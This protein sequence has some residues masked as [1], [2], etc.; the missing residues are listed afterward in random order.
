[1]LTRSRRAAQGHSWAPL[2]RFG[3]RKQLHGVI[4]LCESASVRRLRVRSG[5]GKP[6]VWG[7]CSFPP[8][9]P[10]SF[11]ANEAPRRLCFHPNHPSTR[12]S[13][14]ADLTLGDWKAGAQR[15]PRTSLYEAGPSG[16]GRRM[17]A[18]ACVPRAV[19]S[20]PHLSPTPV[21]QPHPALAL[22]PT[23]HLHLLTLSPYFP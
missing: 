6:K 17:F 23:V 20:P 7:S 11:Y 4:D 9:E 5:A 19:N 1:M 12:L 15:E 18:V 8:Q 22:L 10:P 3:P 2:E 13:W 21:G 16:P 14:D